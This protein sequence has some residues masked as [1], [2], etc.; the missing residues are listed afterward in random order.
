MVAKPGPFR[1]NPPPTTPSA[2]FSPTY[3]PS[4]Y[5][6]RFPK[7]TKSTG[8]INRLNQTKTSLHPLESAI[9][10]VQ[11]D[12]PLSAAEVAETVID[13]FRCFDCNHYETC[14]DL[15]AVL[16][17]YSFTC[18]GCNGMVDPQLIWRAHQE[19]KKKNELESICSLPSLKT[20]E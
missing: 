6:P 17:W 11:D 8:P 15:T 5:K 10:S 9:R 14:L 16:D 1:L 19:L 7:L 12:S 2:K 20:L 13:P 3:R 18:K 4:Q